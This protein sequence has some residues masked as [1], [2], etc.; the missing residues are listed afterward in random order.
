MN[1]AQNHVRNIAALFHLANRVG[2]HLSKHIGTKW[3]SNLLV[4]CNLIQ[5][6]LFFSLV[7]VAEWRRKRAHIH[8]VYCVHM[9]VNFLE[10]LI[11]N[12]HLRYIK[13]RETTN[14]SHVES[15]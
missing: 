11:T 6:R 7:P 9:H 10:K 5:S 3:Y 2:S 4:K 1:I 13:F 8:G 15:G 14:F 12:G